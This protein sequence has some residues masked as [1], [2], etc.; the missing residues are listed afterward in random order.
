MQP[1]H[2][3][4]ST[5]DALGALLTA[6]ACESGTLHAVASDGALHLRAASGIPTS[7]LDIVRIVPVGKGMAGLAAERKQP[8]S[9]CNLQTDST[10]DISPSAK[11]T[12]LGGSVCVPLL[13]AD[14]SV[15]GTLG[16]GCRAERVFTKDE[17]ARLMVAG[18]ALLQAIA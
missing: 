1:S 3:N 12:G 4:S 15:R 5:N 14:G 2:G 7:V 16:V 11:A 10:G 18:A 13:S 8:V 17:E 9:T 6:F